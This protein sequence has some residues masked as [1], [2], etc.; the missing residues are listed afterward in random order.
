MKIAF[1][2]LYIAARGLGLDKFAVAAIAN[3]GVPHW[4]ALPL[5]VA[6]LLVIAG[7]IVALI[8]FVKWI[9]SDWKYDE[10]KISAVVSL[11]LGAAS[12]LV[13]PIFLSPV[14]IACGTFSERRATAPDGW[15]WVSAP[16]GWP[17]CSW[18]SSSGFH[19]PPPAAE[20]FPNSSRFSARLIHSIS[21]RAQGNQRLMSNLFRKKSL[22][23]VLADSSDSVEGGHSLKRTL[24]SLSLIALGIGAIIGAGIFVRTAAAAGNNAG[25]AVVYSFILAGVGCGFAGLCYAELAAMIPV[26][27]SAYTYTYATLGELIAWI[28]GWDLVLEYALGAATVSVAW[29]EY[30]NN[31]LHHFGWGIPF[32][33]CHSPFDV[34]DPWGSMD[35]STCPRFS[36]LPCLRVC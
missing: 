18:P 24:S 33:W 5:F 31:L 23:A 32:Q 34:S 10:G 25:P 21:I 7:A 19:K 8:G 16:W 30:L 3:L 15:V 26:S 27:G 6:L 20:L 1:W 2:A 35:S 11:V 17:G 29:S 14:A 9:F 4:M 13:A 28:I 12:F 22:A 36:F